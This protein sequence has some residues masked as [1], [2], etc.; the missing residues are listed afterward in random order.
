MIKEKFENVMNETDAFLLYHTRTSALGPM[1]S[2]NK[3]VIV[4]DIHC[5]RIHPDQEKLF[6]KRCHRVQARFDERNRIIF[7]KQQLISALQAKIEYP[8]FE[9][10]DKFLS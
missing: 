8:N 10:F 6:Y 5:E 1:L 2:T 9:I 4:L 3:P 7:D